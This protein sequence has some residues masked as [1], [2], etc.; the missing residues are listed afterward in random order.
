MK[1]L[2]ELV[3]RS[4]TTVTA[5]GV[6]VP[7]L[8]LVLTGKDLSLPWSHDEHPWRWDEERSYQEGLFG[9]AIQSCRR[10]LGLTDFQR[11]NPGEPPTKVQWDDPSSSTLTE[12]TS[13]R[14]AHQFR[15]DS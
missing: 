1:V 5:H 12:S 6:F 9:T 3:E 11:G 14:E 15:D 2:R 13:R 10:N 4:T 8:P 7:R